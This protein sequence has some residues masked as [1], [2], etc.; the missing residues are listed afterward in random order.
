[1]TANN[2]VFIN[3][4]RTASAYVALAIYQELRA[5]S[6]DSFYDIEGIDSGQFG[7]IIL[8]QIAA[9]P[10]F[11]PILTPGTLERCKE[12]GDWVLREME[13]AMQLGRV[14][15]PVHTPE[16]NFKDIDTYL[17]PVLATHLKSYNM[18]E[19]PQRFFKYAI[20]D[21]RERF[22][23][24]ITLQTTAPSTADAAIVAQKQD[25][26]AAKPLV[27]EKQLTA[28]EYFVRGLSKKENEDWDGAIADYTE[29]IRLDPRNAETYARRAGARYGKGD[30][31]GTISDCTEAIRLDP[32]NANAY[33]N[34]ALAREAK[35]DLDGTIS[36]CTEAIR[37]NPQNAYSYDCR[38]DARKAKGDLDGAIAD[39]TEA[40]RLD[41]QYAIAYNDRGDAREAK[42]DLDGAIADYTEAIR[43]NSQY[44]SA[45]IH[46]GNVHHAKKDYKRTAADYRKVLELDPNNSQAQVMRG[47]IKRWGN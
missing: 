10:Y 45:Y 19:I 16:F 39:Y 28:Q 6:I 32:H 44:V 26:L 34:C 40:I 21:V 24:P 43:L 5:H 15:V 4:R 14:F 1:M 18:M 2:D 3:Y 27:T 17:P 41:P 33:H 8:S 38:G 29:A 30:L 13:H 22:L 11:M 23:K 9:R 31:D 25:A 42:G 36:D 7:N 46:R 20:Q 12:P 35:G 37:L 47:Y